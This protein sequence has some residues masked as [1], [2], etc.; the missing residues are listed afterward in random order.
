[1]SHHRAREVVGLL[2]WAALATLAVGA[3]HLAGGAMLEPP[4]LTSPQTWGKWLDGRDPVVAA[5]ALGR[6]LALG[7]AG[8]VAVVTVLGTAARL[9]S[10]DRVAAAV[11]RV[12]LP[13]VRRLVVATMSVSLGTGGLAPAHA[14]DRPLRATAATTTT[15]TAAVAGSDRGPPSTITMRQLPPAVGVAPELP[16]TGQPPA[17]AARGPATGGRTWTVTPGQCFWS[18]AEAV[19]TESLGR[20]PVPREVVP[21]WER[22]IEANRAAL[23]DPGNADLV[24]PGQVFTVPVP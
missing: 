9:M 11:D 14:G 6:L 10:G 4:D 21:Y 13:V 18:I 22:L 20:T 24:F 7:A 17:P 5:F 1:M 3:L 12:T 2:L 23:A 16:S 19:L 8:Y 15:T